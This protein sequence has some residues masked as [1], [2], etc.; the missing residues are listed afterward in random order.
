MSVKLVT[1]LKLKIK[2]GI[3]YEYCHN[4][5]YV[6]DFFLF[7]DVEALI[8]RCCKE[9]K[10]IQ[11]KKLLLKIFGVTLFPYNVHYT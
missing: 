6:I 4:W 7:D 2:I 11:I 9:V 10:V 1:F 8:I 5:H 3:Y